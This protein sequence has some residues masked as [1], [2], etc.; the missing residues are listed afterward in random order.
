MS[1]EELPREPLSREKLSREKLL[2]LQQKLWDK[3][4]SQEK[5]LQEGRA[6]SF[7]RYEEAFCMFLQEGVPNLP[8]YIIAYVRNNQPHRVYVFPTSDAPQ[9]EPSVTSTSETSSSFKRPRLADTP[10]APQANV[11]PPSETID[12]HNNAG[13]GEEL[14]TSREEEHHQKVLRAHN[15]GIPRNV[16]AEIFD[17]SENEVNAIVG[18]PSAK[19]SNA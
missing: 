4:L 6:D 19:K 9:D 15:R 2:A 3:V 18:Q 13:T 17:I 5:A 1:Q 12:L 8:R 10:V 7:I 11:C 16:I 14:G